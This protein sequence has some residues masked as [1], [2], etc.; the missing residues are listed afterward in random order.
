[1]YLNGEKSV[2]T[3]A[4]NIIGWSSRDGSV[5]QKTSASPSDRLR[6]MGDKVRLTRL[7]VSFTT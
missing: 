1:M 6:K 5:K 3:F 2:G 4:A 7:I